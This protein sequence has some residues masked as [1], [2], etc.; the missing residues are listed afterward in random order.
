MTPWHAP[1]ALLALLLP[2][3]ALA[4]PAK[5]P[6]Q[7]T[8]LGE[9]VGVPPGEFRMGHQ[10]DDPSP[11]GSLW[12]VNEGPAHPVTL[13][14]F[15]IHR[16]EVTV[17]MW[18]EFLNKVGGL[19]AWHP[20]QGVQRTPTGFAPAVD[21][22]QPARAV[23]WVEARAFCRWHGLELPTE[24][25]WERAA[26]G[27]GPSARTWPW[28]EDPADCRRANLDGGRGGCADGPVP[29]GT[30]GALGAS[31]DGVEDLAGNVAEWVLDWEAPYTDAPQTDPTGPADGEFKVIRGGSFLEWTLRGRVTARVAAPPDR[32]SV[33]VGFRCAG[34]AR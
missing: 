30:Y 32:R 26:R 22:Q 3:A 14:A 6:V 31:P 24:A 7:P 4:Q 21:P 1:G 27:G 5:V 13:S 20:L 8:L 29:V 12:K 19:A 11:T 10:R 16:H 28:G 18:V 33:A 17:A 23:S 2:A 15:Q 9:P 34:G 25:Q